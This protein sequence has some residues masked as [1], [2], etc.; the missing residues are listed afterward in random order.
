MTYLGL[1]FN[2]FL[3]L[4]RNEKKVVNIKQ[5]GD[6]GFGFNI[7]GGR[8]I[9]YVKELSTSKYLEFQDQ[10][11]N[12]NLTHSHVGKE[13]GCGVF[14]SSV[15]PSSKAAQNGLKVLSYMYDIIIIWQGIVL[16]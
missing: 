2:S 15:L 16:Q 9:F 14:V 7:R 12:A 4:Y 6:G 8:E 1:K 5:A 11:I 13:F 10:Q 3:S